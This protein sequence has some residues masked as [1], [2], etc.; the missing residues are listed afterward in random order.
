MD[1]T[2]IKLGIKYSFGVEL[3]DSGVFGTLLPPDQI[4]PNSEESFAALKV[5]SRLIE[6]K[7]GEEELE[8]VPSQAENKISQGRPY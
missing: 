7:L 1:Y 5:V 3:R 2:F 6:K 4:I 8:E